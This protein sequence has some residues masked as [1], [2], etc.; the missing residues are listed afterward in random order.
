MYCFVSNGNVCKTEIELRRYSKNVLFKKIA[1]IQMSKN[2]KTKENK[3][4]PVNNL[5]KYIKLN[6]DT[7]GNNL[8]I[9]SLPYKITQIQTQ[10]NGTQTRTQINGTQTQTQ[11]NGTQIRTQ[12]YETKRQKQIYETQKRKTKTDL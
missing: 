4:E 5:F 9:H 11:I 10:I 2:L 12:I 1:L 7:N 3:N 8:G 6:P